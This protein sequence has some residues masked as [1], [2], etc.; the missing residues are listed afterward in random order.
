MSYKQCSS[1]PAAPGC[2]VRVA[3]CPEKQDCRWF[4]QFQDCSPCGDDFAGYSRSDGCVEFSVEI[5]GEQTC[6]I[7]RSLT[8]TKNKDHPWDGA[9]NKLTPTWEVGNLCYWLL[10]EPE[11]LY[12]VVRA[13]DNITV[14]TSTNAA[15][16]T[17]YTVSGDDVAPYP[18]VSGGDNVTV[19]TSTN[20]AG[21][22]VYTVSVDAPEEIAVDPC[23]MV[24]NSAGVIAAKPQTWAPSTGPV[25]AMNS[26]FR[27]EDGQFWDTPDGVYH[28]QVTV[29]LADLGI[30]Q[31]DC[32]W[33][34]IRV[35]FRQSRRG[36]YKAGAPTQVVQP[37]TTI[38]GGIHAS[39]PFF[40]YTRGYNILI[41]NDGSLGEQDREGR[42]DFLIIPVGVG[43]SVTFEHI[44]YAFPDAQYFQHVEDVATVVVDGAVYV[45]LPDPL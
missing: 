12:P 28:T 3:K 39:S 24:Q 5:D 37:G 7:G 35:Q 26:V 10:K 31:D 27:G 32:R 43:G 2:G 18:M 41:N 19:T 22:T 30:P 40:D 44:I 1:A 16:Q 45:E 9:F 36:D 34:A 11:I 4:P 14:T 23:T 17:V 33:N 42:D 38:K 8:E 29:S 15:G 25:V 13:G 20:G 21:Q 6:F